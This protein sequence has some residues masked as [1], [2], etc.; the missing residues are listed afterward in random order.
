MQPDDQS[1]RRAGGSM[2]VNPGHSRLVRTGAAVG[3]ATAAALAWY[4]DRYSFRKARRPLPPVVWRVTAGRQPDLGQVA[5]P[6]TEA[7]PP[8]MLRGGRATFVWTRRPSWFDAWGNL[9]PIRGPVTVWRI[10]TDSIA[11]S[12]VR[13]RRDGAA[14]I[15]GG[16]SGPA[17]ANYY[18]NWRDWVR[19]HGLDEIGGPHPRGRPDPQIRQPR[20]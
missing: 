1:G 2:A 4:V 20:G 5:F 6:A 3:L 8:V 13:S 9:F 11:P 18:E 16:Y 15:L 19:H 7:V 10:P 14:A 17:T 12:A